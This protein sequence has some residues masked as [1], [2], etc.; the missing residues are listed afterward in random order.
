MRLPVSLWLPLALGVAAVAAG[1]SPL[2]RRVLRDALEYFHGRSNVHF[3]FKE[4]DVDGV[5]ERVSNGIGTGIRDPG[6]GVAQGERGGEGVME[7]VGRDRDRGFGLQGVRE[8]SG[9]EQVVNGVSERGSDRTG[10]GDLG[11]GTRGDRGNGESVGVSQR[12]QREG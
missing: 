3:L 2:Q 10:D 9:R 4:R 12:E 6:A 7:G 11:F 8:G 1:Q 5:I